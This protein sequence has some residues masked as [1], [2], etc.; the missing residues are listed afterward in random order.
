VAERPEE[1]GRLASGMHMASSITSIG[2]EFSL[3]VGIGFW[4]DRRWHT[5]PIGTMIG[6]VL[7]FV[8]GMMHIMAVAKNLSA[9]PPVSKVVRPS[10]PPRGSGPS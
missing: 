2:L 10:K 4:I 3:P 1:R 5:T 6:A 8:A 9:P 7:G